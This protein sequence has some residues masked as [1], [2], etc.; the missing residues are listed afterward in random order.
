MSKELQD[1]QNSLEKLW[2]ADLQNSLKKLW[3]AD[4]RNVKEDGTFRGYLGACRHFIGQGHCPKAS[5]RIVGHLKS[6]LGT[7]TLSDEQALV[8]AIFAGLADYYA[9]EG[10]EAAAARNHARRDIAR[11]DV[12]KSI[13]AMSYNELWNALQR[14]IISRLAKNPG[15]F[16]ED[17]HVKDIYAEDFVVEIK[18]KYYMASYS[19]LD[20]HLASVGDIQ[21]ATMKFVRTI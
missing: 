3:Q 19:I 18:G 9:A 2:Q 21:P 4:R 5:K 11:M 12:K 1:L 16:P 6:S 15:Y 17:V 7:F 8:N 10:L 13:T 20:G 14:V